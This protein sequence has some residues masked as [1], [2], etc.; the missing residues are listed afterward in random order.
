MQGIGY[1]LYEDFIV[2][3]NTGRTLTD[4]FAG[5][6]IPT[7]LETPEIDVILVEEAVSSGPYGAKGVGESGL[8]NVASAIANAVYDAVG[9]R[10]RSL[11][12]TP[13]KVIKALEKQ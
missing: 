6:K 11:P 13:E 8:V 10:M 4:S 5:Y 12:I 7:I 9:V 1:A 3:E 2:D